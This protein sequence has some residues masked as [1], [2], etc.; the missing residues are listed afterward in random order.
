MRAAGSHRSHP[1]EH[2]PLKNE[3]PDTKRLKLFEDNEMQNYKIQNTDHK[4]VKRHP[5]QSGDAVMYGDGRLGPHLGMP[6]L[7]VLEQLLEC[8]GR[9]EGGRQGI[10][11]AVRLLAHKLLVL[12][13]LQ[14]QLK[15]LQRPRELGLVK[16]SISSS[17]C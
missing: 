7:C 10:E 11:S 4:R 15:E 9:G 8:G 17:G 14:E 12:G 3:D 13:R 2:Q 1:H 5:H 16:G 6:V